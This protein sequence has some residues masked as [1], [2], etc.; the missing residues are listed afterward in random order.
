MDDL[1]KLQKKM[2]WAIRISY[3]P[4]EESTYKVNGDFLV[5]AESF[6][7]AVSKVKQLTHKGMEIHSVHKQ[8]VDFLV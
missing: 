6:D 4:K 8:R 2:A 5:L 3:Y 1:I 7:E